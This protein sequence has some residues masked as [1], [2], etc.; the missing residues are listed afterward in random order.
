MVST[1]I[2]PVPL[3][4]RYLLFPWN[5]TVSLYCDTFSLGRVQVALPVPL[6][7][8]TVCE[9]PSGNI[10]VTLP[11]NGTPSSVATLIGIVTLSPGEA[12]TLPTLIWVGIGVTVTLPVPLE[13]KYLLFPS[14][15]AFT[16]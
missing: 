15:L 5:K 6:T 2:I 7:I 11:L 10:I 13:G 16:E 4:G 9:L 14:K 12:V 8:S 1:E 3:E